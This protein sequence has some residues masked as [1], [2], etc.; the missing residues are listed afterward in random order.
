MENNITHH[1]TGMRRLNDA[2][3]SQRIC[4]KK[5]TR[6]RVNKIVFCSD[7]ETLSPQ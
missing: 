4:R 5:N 7:R 2:H 1:I 3:N 6:E